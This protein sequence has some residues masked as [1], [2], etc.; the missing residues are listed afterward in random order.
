MAP[1]TA[2][3]RDHLAMYLSQ[4]GMSINQFAGQCGINSG[5]LSRLLNGQQPIAMNHLER[6]TRG[7]QLPEDHFYSLYVDECFHH[8][9]PS[10]RRLRPFLLRA[11][12]LGRLDCIERVV[13]NL[14]ENLSYA[15][16]LF[17]VAEGLFQQGLWQAAALLYKNVS[18][19]EKYQNSERLAVCQFRLF[20]ISLGDDQTLNLQAALLFECYLD[21]L[22]EADQLDGLKHLINAYYSLHQWNKV[23]KLAQEMLHLATLR[24][25]LKSHFNRKFNDEK[26]PEKPLC[27]YILYS[28]LMRA[29]ISEEHHDYISALKFVTLYMDE[30]WIKEV[31]VDEEV[32]RTVEQFKEWG[33]ANTLL[34]QV[35]SG[36]HETLAAY[37][38]YISSRKDEIFV[39]LYNILISANQYDWNIDYILKRFAY[40]IPYRTYS[41]EFGEYNQQI[42]KDQYAR[43]LAELAIYY[44]HNK[45]NE[46]ISLILQSLE[47][48]AKINN[49][50]I[51]IK[52]V[53]LF[54][55]HRHLANK[56][57]KQKYKLLIR[58]VQD[59]NEKKAYHAASFV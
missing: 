48:S 47:S 24:Y 18:A 40:Y 19:S 50:T 28:H 26:V 34:Y 21:K 46:G 20:R 57:E 27:F 8:S 44:L 25:N 3:I 35:R 17:E 31:K 30:S 4:Q 41:T 29:S 32:Q 10:W 14:L 37:V 15:P 42:M 43:F 13:Q 36:Q 1:I 38:E 11:A 2:T 33:T 39:A 6:I 53:D 51:I 52:C 54:E 5:T 59:L 16:M 23:D 56:A 49:E 7:M 9:P 12:D 22:D 45:R 55:Q 58:E